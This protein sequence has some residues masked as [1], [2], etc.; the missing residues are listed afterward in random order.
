MACLSGY[1]EAVFLGGETLR[2]SG[3]V[4]KTASSLKILNPLEHENPGLIQVS[5]IRYLLL[6]RSSRGSGRV[7]LSCLH[8]SS[9]SVLA[10]FVSAAS[11][12]GRCPLAIRSS[13]LGS[14]KSW[15]VNSAP[16]RMS[17]RALAKAGHRSTVCSSTHKRSSSSS[18]KCQ[19]TGQ[20]YPGGRTFYTPPFPSGKP[21]NAGPPGSW[22]R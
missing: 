20:S 17:W 5:D 3:T 21:T 12:S 1:N 11:K 16:A 7:S 14:G 4:A 2:H 10:S 6:M 22:K 8:Q 13:A 18:S 19:E 9:L 15:A